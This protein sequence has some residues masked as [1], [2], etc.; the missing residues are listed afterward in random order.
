MVFGY[1]NHSFPLCSW[2]METIEGNKSE[3]LNK[4]SSTIGQYVIFM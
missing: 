1:C 3:T 4:W 2:M